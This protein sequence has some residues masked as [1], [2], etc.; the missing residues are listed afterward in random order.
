MQAD[1]CLNSEQVDTLFISLGGQEGGGGGGGSFW[2]GGQNVH[3][4]VMNLFL[5]TPPARS[6]IFKGGKAV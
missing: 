1:S 6:L 2:A 4:T 5:F 3:V